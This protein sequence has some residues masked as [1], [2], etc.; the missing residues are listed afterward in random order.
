MGRKFAVDLRTKR[1]KLS[2]KAEDLKDG[3]ARLRAA[4]DKDPELLPSG[5]EE[6]AIHRSMGFRERAAALDS[7][8]RLEELSVFVYQKKKGD[9][10]YRYWKAEWRTPNGRIKQVHLGPAEG[11]NGLSEGEA[12]AKARKLK[13]EDLGLSSTSY[14]G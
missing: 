6:N 9:K 3:A 13:A 7:S 12:L 5:L 2:R 11:K 4:Y 14:I 1:R 8:I 10:S